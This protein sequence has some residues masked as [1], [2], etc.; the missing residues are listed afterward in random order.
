MPFTPH[1]VVL[2]IKA[3][4]QYMWFI[5]IPQLDYMKEKYN[6]HQVTYAHRIDNILYFENE[7]YTFSFETNKS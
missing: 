5:V 3:T 2:T 6:I 1:T 4:M 7:M